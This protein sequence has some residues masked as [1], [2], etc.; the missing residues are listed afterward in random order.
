MSATLNLKQVKRSVCLPVFNWI[1]P[2][3]NVNTV[4]DIIET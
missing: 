3:L 2:F 4:D 1:V